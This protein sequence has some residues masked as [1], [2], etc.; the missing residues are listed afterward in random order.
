MQRVRFLAIIV[1]LCSLTPSVFAQQES[2][3]EAADR[4]F[5]HAIDLF[6]KEKYAAAQ[7][8]FDNMVQQ[9]T[10]YEADAAYY[11]AVCS[12]ELGSN[13]AL[14]RLDEF[15]RLFPHSSKTGMARFYQGN[16]HYARS[17]YSKALQY[18]KQVALTDIEYGH[19]NE[20]DFKM[21]YCY[22]NTGDY[23]QAKTCLARVKDGK[24]KYQSSALYYYAH[25]Q[26]ME[27]NYELALSNFTKLQRDRRF[28]KIVPSY[29]ARIY[30]YLGREDE[31]LQLAPTLMEDKDIFK[32]GE[33]QQMI[34]EVYFN[35]GEYSQALAYYRKAAI[36][37]KQEAPVQG[38]VQNDNTYQMGYC[39]YMLHNYDSATVYLSRKTSCNDSIAQNA[40]YTL[41]DA[42]LKLGRKT[43]AR[44]AF[45]Q[46]SRMKFDSAISE[47]ALF[48]YAK[49]SCELGANPYNENIRSLE[50]YLKTYPKTKHKEEIQ[51]LLAQLYMNTRN[52]KDALRLIEKIE[53]KSATLNQAYQRI[54]INRGIECFNERN[55]QEASSFFQK[56]IK[57]NALPK[58]TADAHYL[59]AECQY[60]LENMP[61]SGRAFDKFFLS[62]NAKNSPYYPQALYT[63][64]Y[65]C[66]RNEKYSDAATSFTNFL[67]AAGRDVE[68][69]QRYDA[70]NRLGDCRY[71]L[72][73]FDEAITQYDRVINAKAKDA[74]YATYQKALCFG[75]MGK[76]E[77]KLTYLNYI[78]E[79]HETSSL[80]PKA[81]FEIANTYM[82]CDNN[83]MA[84]LYFS[85][86]VKQYPHSAHVK[87]ALLNMGLIYYNT[88]RDSLALVCF[89]KLLNDYQGT[90]EARDA[91][92]TV[93][94]IYVAQN[95][96]DEYFD[97]VARTTHTTVRSSEQD[98][99][100]FLAAANRYYEGDCDRA[101]TGLENY[102][103]R[104][105][106]GLFMLKAHYFAADCLYKS[107]LHEKALPHY[108]TVG[109]M[110]KN[111]YTESSLLRAANIAYGLGSYSKAA[112][113][114]TRLSLQAETDN[115]RLQSRA[116]LLRCWA[117]LEDHAHVVATADALLAEPK[118][119]PDLRDEAILYQARSYFQRKDYDSAAAKYT[120][121]AKA[122]NG[123]YQGEARY[124]QAEMHFLSGNLALAEKD[125]EAITANPPSDYW[126]AKSFILW[127]DIFNAR[128]NTMQA[129]QTLQSI[130][131]NYDGEDLVD[132]ALQKRNA[133]LA[134]EAAAEA[135]RM[136][137][138]DIEDEEIVITLPS[139]DDN[140]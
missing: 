74:D 66:M 57:I 21:G 51:E 13:D 86:F 129:K 128:G 122:T 30:Y 7:H 5:R 50:D 138:E 45:L 25:L 123:E 58:N 92:P 103:K 135:D 38:C 31:L 27:G 48:N 72:K 110:N 83:D 9:G 87:E 56:A 20:Y 102:L 59:Y 70:Y 108:E 99:T 97:Y 131:D 54:V 14:F 120:L 26:Y 33:L 111:Q 81:L 49:L 121:L 8:E 15:L 107:G 2:K 96:V 42:Y 22:I 60:R 89:D 82:V 73:Q 41:G 105:P 68:A 40:L 116:G 125:I 115:V 126:L 106:H 85:N 39:Y 18:Y 23:E 10:A 140:E 19:R 112:E 71:A 130:I 11:G 6:N 53:P 16:T 101:I 100:T 12:S 77:E 133:I 124:R 65:L 109:R 36:A 4:A 137:K 136:Q 88:N 114:Y 80:A 46:S 64:G 37:N 69:S 44:S 98:S 55:I 34:G 76:N 1:L 24:S 119:T 17:E 62:T 93:K 47:D 29:L 28:A 127:A 139:A 3:A 104:F 61:A 79:R 52:Y 35:R 95:R 90:D 132:E 94:N 118:I 117:R 75:A 134:A 32:K 113:Y 78:F 67:H 63:Y 43:E 91:I 84:V